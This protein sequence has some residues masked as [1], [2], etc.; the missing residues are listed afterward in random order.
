MILQK[1]RQLMNRTKHTTKPLALFLSLLISATTLADG[2]KDN[3]PDKV[4]QIPRMGVEPTQAEKAELEKGLSQLKNL[5]TQL[6]RK[7][8]KPTRTLIPDIEIYYR[9]VRTNLDHREFFNKGDINK[10]R[11]LLKVGIERARQLLTGNTPWTTATGLVVRGYRSKI[12]GTVQPYGLIVPET[13]SAKSAHGYRL[14]LWFHGRGET[15]SETNFIFQRERSVGR[16]APANTF[17]LHPYGRYSNAFKFAGEIDVL[18]ALAHAQ[19]HYRIDEDRISVRGFSMGG[20]GCWQFA[21]HYADRLFASNPGAG[22]SETPEFL[23]Y[24]QRETL[25]PTWYE[26][27]LWAMYDCPGYAI[28]LY[29]CPTVAYSGELDIQKQAADIMEDALEKVGIDLLHLIGPKTRHNIHPESAKEI[30]RRMAALAID[31]RQRNPRTV[32]FATYTLKY[33]RMHWVTVNAIQEHWRRAGLTASVKNPGSI[34]IRTQGVTDLS[35]NFPPGQT[36]L[37]MRTPVT[38]TIDGTKLNGPKPK[39]DRSFHMQFYRVDG[40]WRIGPPPNNKRSLVKRHNLQGPID[41]AFMDSFIFVK[42]TGRAAHP[43]VEKWTQSEFA[44]AVKH[45]RQQFRGDARVKTASQITKADIANSNLVLFGDPKSNPLIAKVIGRLPIHWSGTK[46]SI[47][48]R[49]F[50][51]KHHAPILIFPNPL[52]PKKYVVLNSGFT[53]R[54][55]AYLNNARQVPMLPDWAIVDLRTP[56]GSQ[57]PGKIVAADFFGER[58]EVRQPIPELKREVIKATRQ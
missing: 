51:A 46:L 27:R 34:V 11:Q 7:K 39:S 10:A 20:A 1:D 48:G 56:A 21:V 3:I 31:G 38:V 4:R 49:N 37:D 13:Y 40:Q 52:N 19:Q 58:W 43:A 15:L 44:H 26:K 28:N 36:L 24:F 35:L 55:F 22:F 42:P 23:R 18:E 41:D 57:Y 9:A 8:D 50:D 53:Y 32:R 16:F 54:E 29:H 45:W 14:D 6:N 30:E 5:L 25:T 17:V 12:D 33:N 2:P 47:G